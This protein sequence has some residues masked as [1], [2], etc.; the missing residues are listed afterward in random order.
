MKR[1]GKQKVQKRHHN[2]TNILPQIIF[3]TYKLSHNTDYLNNIIQTHACVGKE[4]F[5]IIR[6]SNANIAMLQAMHAYWQT[7]TGCE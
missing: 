4:W 7:R 3:Y 1:K 6:V 2:S 5:V